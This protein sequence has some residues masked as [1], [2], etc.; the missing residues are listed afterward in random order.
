MRG[1]STPPGATSKAAALR[2]VRGRSGPARGRGAEVESYVKNGNEED[3]TMTSRLG[4]TGAGL[5][6]RPRRVDDARDRL[7]THLHPR[8]FDRDDLVGE[9]ATARPGRVRSIS[10][11][12]LSRGAAAQVGSQALR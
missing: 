8:S 5:A 9:V 12:T 7:L 10:A 4:L 6:G 3:E 11:L 1:G 2:T